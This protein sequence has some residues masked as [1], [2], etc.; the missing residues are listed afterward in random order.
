MPAGSVST[1]PT[2]Q[3]PTITSFSPWAVR[4]TTSTSRACRDTDSVSRT[5]RKRSASAITCCT[6][7]SAPLEADPERRRAEL[8]FV[9]VGGG[10]TG[11]EMAGALSELI[12]LVL[13]KDYPRLNVK[14]VRVL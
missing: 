12:R 3:S 4:R 1:P 8:T 11:V 14:D 6:P 13:V 2:G 7:S 10:P 5:F 9:V